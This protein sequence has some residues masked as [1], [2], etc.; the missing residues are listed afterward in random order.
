[1]T[2]STEKTCHEWE[3]TVYGFD[4]Y[5]IVYCESE[6]WGR[7]K[8]HLREGYCIC[9]APLHADG[10][11]GVPYAVVERAL[12]ITVRQYKDEPASLTDDIEWQRL[13]AQAA[14]ELAA[15]AGEVGSD[16]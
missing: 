14:A 7:E 10:T 6:T 2:K 3:W 8:I 11:E 16:G 12:N 5:W 15:E 4:G 13:L 1:M 9:G